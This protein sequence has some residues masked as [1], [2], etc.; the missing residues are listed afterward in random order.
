LQL[1][2]GFDVRITRWG[3]LALMAGGGAAIMWDGRDHVPGAA[4]VSATAAFGPWRTGGGSG[5][6]AHL[7]DF[8][9]G[10]GGPVSKVVV[11]VAEIADFILGWFFVDFRR[12]DYGWE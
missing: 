1:P 2:I 9:I 8:E 4:N 3:Q 11:D 12:D 7:G 6:A 10:W 5:N